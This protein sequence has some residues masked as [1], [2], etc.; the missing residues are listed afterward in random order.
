M[1]IFVSK[2]LAK[3]GKAVPQVLLNGSLSVC[4]WCYPGLTVFDDYPWLRYYQFT[5]GAFEKHSPRPVTH[6]ICPFHRSQ[7]EAEL[8]K[9][10][11]TPEL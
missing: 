5:S 4:A 8:L 10:A 6:C 3:P 11:A 9:I 7:L 1:N 2:S